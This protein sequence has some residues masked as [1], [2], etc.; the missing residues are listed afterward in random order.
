MSQLSL[1]VLGDWL[2]CPSAA[3]TRTTMSA[4]GIA[5]ETSVGGG[6]GRPGRLFRVK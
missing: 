3:N 4:R 1:R 5:R 6:I 2:A